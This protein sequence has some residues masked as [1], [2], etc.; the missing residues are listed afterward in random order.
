MSVYPKLTTLVTDLSEV[1]DSSVASV[2]WFPI[3]TERLRM[4]VIANHRHI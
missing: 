4:L 1:T 3:S 2:S